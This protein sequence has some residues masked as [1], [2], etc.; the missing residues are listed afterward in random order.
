V[1]CQ[2]PV[3]VRSRVTAELRSGRMSKRIR[4]TPKKEIV[5]EERKTVEEVREKD[6][7]TPVDGNIPTLPL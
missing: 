5:R 4:R 3:V 6:E 2:P 1:S 7:W